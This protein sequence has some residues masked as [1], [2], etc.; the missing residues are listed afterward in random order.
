MFVATVTCRYCNKKFDRDKE[1]YIQ[2]P[3]GKSFRYGHADCYLTAVNE[4]KEKEHYE[5]WDP[6][7]S[8]TCFW[9]HQAIY[10]NQSDV[11]E[12][13]Q[14]K[15]RY[16]H[17]KCAEIRPQ[18]DKDQLMLYI[19]KLYN[20]K[21]DYILPRFMLQVSNF[22]KN[23][24]FTYSGMLKALKYWYE[25]KKHPIDKD[26]GLGIIPYIYKQAYD[27]Y[28]ALWQAD[29]QNK[30]KDL[31]EYIPKDIVMVIR[32]PQRKIEKR[33]LFTF[34]DEEIEENNAE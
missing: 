17:K 8:T 21:D 22:E 13:P 30:Q 9:C 19:I 24:H 3:L 23:Y 29:E 2:V 15:G 5:I 4:G 26:K 20:L 1:A 10:S 11:I 27:Y 18:D 32:P 16:V 6:K 7:H 25:V 14:L 12:M 33:E 28:Y 34:L 31:S